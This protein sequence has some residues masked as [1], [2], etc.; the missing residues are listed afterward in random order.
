MRS[1][2]TIICQAQASNKKAIAVDLKHPEGREVFHRLL[3]TADVLVQNFTSGCLPALGLEA[4]TLRA[5]KSDLIY[6]SISGYGRNGSGYGRNGPKSHDPAYDNVIQS[7]TGI[8]C[9]NSIIAISLG[10]VHQK[11]SV[12]NTKNR[13]SQA[14]HCACFP[15]DR[16]YPFSAQITT[17]L[18]L[19]AGICWPET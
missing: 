17:F 10:Q 19:I 5:I 9:A 1:S 15:V 2:M 3:A 11:R 13:A 8:M 12:L 7:F 6:C 14:T 18:S 16:F 4:H